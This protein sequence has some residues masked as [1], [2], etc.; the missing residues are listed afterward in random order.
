MNIIKIKQQYLLKAL[1]TPALCVLVCLTY[2][3]I[4]ALFF[5][6]LPPFADGFKEYFTGSLQGVT[7]KLNIGSW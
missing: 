2:T 3:A 6:L 7:S 5:I 4:V 1:P